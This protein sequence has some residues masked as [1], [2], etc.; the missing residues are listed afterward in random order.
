MSRTIS[1]RGT[2]DMG[3]Q[4]RIKLSTLKGKVGYK[5]NK[6]QIMSTL[7][8]QSGKS[9]EYVAQIFKTDQTGSITPDVNF[10]NSDLL[11][12]IHLQD[13]QASDNPAS[14]IIIFDNEVFN[15]DIFVT[16][17]DADGDT[18]PGNYYIELETMPLSDLQAT[19]LTLKNLRSIASDQ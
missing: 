11:A 19:Q 3:T 15:Q 14:E 10:T 16:M 4:D 7:P 9:V 2:L 5:I 6:F 17:Q 12:V 13:Q 8:G 18:V 1:F